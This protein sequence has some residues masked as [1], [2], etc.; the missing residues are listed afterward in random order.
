MKTLFKPT[1][2]HSGVAMAV[3]ATA[4]WKVLSFANALLIAAYFGAGAGTD[5]YFYLMMLLGFALTFLQRLNAAVIIPEAMAQDS[6][7][8]LSGR[9][10]LNQFLYIY[11]AGTVLLA[12]IGAVAPAWL[13]THISRFETVQ[14][15][16]QQNLITLSCCLFG[17]QLLVS[18]LTAILEMYRRFATALLSPLNALLPLVCLLL[19]GRQVGI[20]SMIYGFLAANLVQLAVFSYALRKDLNWHFSVPVRSFSGMFTKNLIS[21]QTIELANIV[22]SLLPLYLLS[23]LAA[24]MVSALNYAKQLSDSA[25]EILTLR[26][27]NVSKIQ[28][29]ENATALAW[30]KF[31]R[32]YNVTHHFL[33]FLL[34]PLAVFS[35]F[36]APEIITLFFKRGAFSMQDAHHAAGFLRPLLGLMWL[37]VPILMQNN[38]VVATRKLK[39]FLPYT[40]AGIVL[41]IA[42]VPLTMHRW[43]ALAYPYTQLICCV[44]GIAINA[45]YFRRYL[46]QFA[47][48][49]SLQEG[50]RLLACSIIALLPSA[51]YAWFV[52]GKNPWVTVLIGGI[53]FMTGLLLLTKYSGD[54]QRFAHPCRPASSMPGNAADKTADCGVR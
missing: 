33:W 30:D 45:L 34:T 25:T 36:Y 37:M 18:Y 53:I 12:V 29:T 14:I 21:N 46:P 13:G 3:S 9:I 7:T 28:L 44:L 52:A 2:Y 16:S 6:Q 54:L 41:F 20:V 19:F 31:N 11:V 1:S 47:L 10:L 32:D 5:L 38:A 51:V 23:G 26:V 22:S 49:T 24:G 48:R 43:G 27:T 4:V 42:T 35:I 8:P 39:D 17:L 50:A 40:L 15:I